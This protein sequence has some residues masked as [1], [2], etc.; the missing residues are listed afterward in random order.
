MVSVQDQLTTTEGPK[1]CQDE[2]CL[3]QERHN[4]GP[5]DIKE[6]LQESSEDRKNDMLLCVWPMA[7]EPS[8][9]FDDPVGNEDAAGTSS[10]RCWR[11]TEKAEIV[12]KAAFHT[13]WFDEPSATHAEDSMPNQ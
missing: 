4:I 3:E 8:L 2:G 13:Y 6:L 7:G 9:V 1:E 10:K 11:V 12:G 5:E